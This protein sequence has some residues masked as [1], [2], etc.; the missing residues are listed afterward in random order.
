VSSPP[1]IPASKYHI[2]S[3]SREQTQF[4]LQGISTTLKII[5]SIVTHNWLKKATSFQ[6]LAKKLFAIKT[7]LQTNCGKMVFKI[8]KTRKS[9][10]NLSI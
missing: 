7:Q 3:H 9:F 1:V 4:A 10:C 5:K 8:A 2:F 6:L